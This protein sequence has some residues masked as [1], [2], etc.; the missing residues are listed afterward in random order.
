MNGCELMSKSMTMRAASCV[1]P[2]IALSLVVLEAC[3]NATTGEL[4][5]SEAVVYGTIVDEAGALRP[6]AQ[7]DVRIY[8]PD[9]DQPNPL[10]QPLPGI[11]AD[12][13]YRHLLRAG[14]FDRLMVCVVVNASVQTPAGLL[15]G[16]VR[17]S[18]VELRRAGSGP[19]DSVRVNVV[20]R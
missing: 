19:L 4:V 20:V 16:T 15:Q 11:A 10:L 1:L 6:G 18:T 5:P 9:C 7:F 2:A 12:G 3:A 13:S 17:D 8:A 14:H